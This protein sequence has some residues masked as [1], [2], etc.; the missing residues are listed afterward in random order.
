MSIVF[1]ITNLFDFAIFIFSMIILIIGWI[2]VMYKTDPPESIFIM[3]WISIGLITPILTFMSSSC[4][5]E[6]LKDN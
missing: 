6:F 5:F 2:F 4:K 1:K 3:V